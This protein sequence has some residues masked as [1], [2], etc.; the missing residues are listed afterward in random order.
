MIMAEDLSATPAIGK[1]GAELGQ[2]LTENKAQ[3][4]AVSACLV[5]SNN[6]ITIN[7]A[8]GISNGGIAD[9]NAI[10][11]LTIQESGAY[12]FAGWW[13][14]AHFY[15]GWIPQNVNYV[16]M[17]RDAR[18]TGF[19][20]PISGSVSNASALSYN[21]TGTNQQLAEHWQFL[22]S[23]YTWHGEV[24]ASLDLG[25]TLSDVL[26]W[27]KQNAQTIEE[28]VEVIVDLAS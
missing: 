20:F 13:S 1:T 19:S 22:Q 26:N 5:G 21:K 16:L 7:A 11:T 15:T 4:A 6:S 25:A 14:P 3:L 24:S 10:A 28:V 12:T 23:G 17:I 9:L 8:P 27:F 2:L 18:G